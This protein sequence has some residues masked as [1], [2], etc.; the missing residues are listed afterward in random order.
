M[1]CP[2]GRHPFQ[3]GSDRPAGATRYPWVSRCVCPPS[4]LE[5]ACEPAVSPMDRTGAAGMGRRNQRELP[6]PRT[7]YTGSSR[8]VLVVVSWS[9]SRVPAGTSLRF[10]LTCSL[11]LAGGK[12]GDS[13][14]GLGSVSGH[15]CAGGRLAVVR[16][17]AAC[18]VPTSFLA[19]GLPCRRCGLAIFARSP[20]PAMTRCAGWRSKRVVVGNDPM[21]KY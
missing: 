15:R 17:S 11:G 2:A 3:I 16:Q 9:R 10:C 18:V 12:A 13:G 21:K 14:P 1:G 5:G 20:G 8:H 6:R 19:H 4:R 7:Q